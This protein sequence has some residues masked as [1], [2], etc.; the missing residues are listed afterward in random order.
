MTS[1]QLERVFGRAR[2]KMATGEHVEVHREAALPGERRRY[3]KRFLS[4]DDADFREWTGREWRVLARLIGHG[5]GCVP[6]V[7]Q[8][9]GGAAGGMRHV[10]TYDAGTTVDQWASL[11]PVRRAGIVRQHVFEDCAHWWSLAM[12]CLRALD[13]V[14]A[15]GLVHLD[16]KADNICIPHAPA[17]FQPD[18][19]GMHLHVA[20]NR[21]A[22][23][24]FAFSVVTGERLGTA[25][26]LGWQ[27]DY[28]YQS[29]RLLR[30]LEAGRD[31]DLGPVVAQDQHTGRHQHE[32]RASPLEPLSSRNRPYRAMPALIVSASLG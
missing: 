9:D 32:D 28:D 14:H 19:Q 27:K 29:P 10:Q 26:P 3:T 4:T 15:L 30:A 31:G 17:S 23:I 24:D 20:F 5:V 16:V 11:L 18:A 6:D 25:L 8:F 7:V 22:L 21:L 12:H 13:E 1:D 2:L